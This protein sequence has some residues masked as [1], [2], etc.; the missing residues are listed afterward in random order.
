MTGEPLGKARVFVVGLASGFGSDLGTTTASDGTFRIDGV[1]FHDAYEAIAIVRKGYE[2][3]V[4][5]NV[6]VDGV[7]KLDAKMNRDW[8][9][10][11]AGARLVSASPPD[12]TEFG[13]GPANA[14]DLS[15]A[16][17]GSDAPK[18]R[19]GSNVTGPRKA[20][21]RLPKAVNV[22]S[23]GVA[24]NGT[25]GD[26]PRAAVKAFTIQTRTQNG[27]WITVV[28][29]NAKN[30]GVLRTYP[31]EGS[32]G[33]RKVRSIRFIMRSTHGDR[34]FMDVVEVTV[35]GR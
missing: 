23:F 32:G 14:F 9:A 8:A 25:C 1:P 33:L 19:F 27:D 17:W 21:V 31:P 29:A 2:R 13:C 26:P 5:R 18:S 15:A 3:R 30:D 7:E 24:S 16:G 34:V 12:Y 4:I 10:L 6:V 11:E 20:V 28:K 35:R 22:T